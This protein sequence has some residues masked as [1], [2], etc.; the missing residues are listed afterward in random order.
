MSILP[1]ETIIEFILSPQKWWFLASPVYK[2]AYV[3]LLIMFCFSIILFFTKKL[4]TKKAGWIFF[5]VAIA[6]TVLPNIL[7]SNVI[8]FPLTLT[9]DKTN[10]NGYIQKEIYIINKADRPKYEVNILLDIDLLDFP[11]IKIDVPKEYTRSENNYD[12]PGTQALLIF[13]II[14]KEKKYIW[15]T[16]RELMANSEFPINIAATGGNIKVKETT[17]SY[18]EMGIDIDPIGRKGSVPLTPFSIL[19]GKEGITVVGMKVILMKN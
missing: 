15:I 13:N 19:K 3:F 18:Q 4:S 16:K 14:Q 17:F 2:I 11:Q 9:F 5:F 6:I 12:F 8:V 7:Y 10:E 1:I